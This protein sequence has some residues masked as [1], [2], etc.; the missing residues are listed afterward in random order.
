MYI[1]KI[2]IQVVLSNFILAKNKESNII[3]SIKDIIMDKIKQFRL[4]FS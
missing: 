2:Q 4:F 3:K 1:T